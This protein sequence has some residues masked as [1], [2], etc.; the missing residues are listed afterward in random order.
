MTSLNTTI[1]SNAPQGTW[2]R[3]S[4]PARATVTLTLDQNGNPEISDPRSRGGF[5]PYLQKGG[6]LFSSPKGM[7]IDV[8]A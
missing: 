2:N 5:Y 1:H 6:V 3:K 4:A 8:S 7:L